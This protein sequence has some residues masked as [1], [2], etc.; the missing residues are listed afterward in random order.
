[1]FFCTFVAAHKPYQSLMIIDIE[2]KKKKKAPPPTI[3]LVTKS[4]KLVMGNTK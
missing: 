1:M 2:R 3:N 4:P